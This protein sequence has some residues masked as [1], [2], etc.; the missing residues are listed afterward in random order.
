M[1]ATPLNLLLVVVFL[2]YIIFPIHCHLCI[3]KYVKLDNYS[4]LDLPSRP[5]VV[6]VDIDLFNLANIDETRRSFMVHMWMILSWI[7]PRLSGQYPVKGNCTQM[8]IKLGDT[9]L[10][11]IWIPDI[12]FLRSTAD[13]SKHLYRENI[14]KIGNNG[15]VKLEFQVYAV[16]GCP[17]DFT[18]YPHDEFKCPIMIESKYHKADDMIFNSSIESN[19]LYNNLNGNTTG[20][21]PFHLTVE[22]VE[23]YM[24]PLNYSVSG[25][26]IRMS[27]I[28]WSYYI[29]AYLPA[30]ILVLASNISFLIPPENIPGR[31]S[32]IVTILLMFITSYNYIRGVT[33]LVSKISYLDVW[34]IGCILFVTMALFE[35]AIIIHIRFKSTEC[36]EKLKARCQKLDSAAAMVSIS[37]YMTFIC[38][39]FTI[40]N[41]AKE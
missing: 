33:P 36:D 21:R 30:V 17:M 10:E 40:A 1:S 32:L 28:T 11:D 15:E 16:F 18:G 4:A 12:I 25:I 19:Y 13:L 41:K 38:I 35:Y 39:Y 26:V 2:N 9:S 27:R 8:A 20:N 34:S 7:D 3:Q 31:M 37:L 14:L 23:D 29:N 24:S 5:T 6:N 22:G